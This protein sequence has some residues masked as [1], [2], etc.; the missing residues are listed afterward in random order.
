MTKI[1]KL[2]WMLVFAV[3]F[4]QM[5]QAQ[6]Q[7]TVTG[8]HA[9]SNG[10]YSTVKLAF[11]AINLQDQTGFNILVGISDNTTET[12][13]AA[14]NQGAWATLTVYPTASGK[15]ISG[16]IAGALIKLNGADNVTIDGSYNGTTQ[17]LTFS[18]DNASTSNNTIA[19]NA[20]A[21]NNTI[22]NCR[23]YSKYRS[24]TTN[25]ADNTLIEGNEIFGDSSGNPFSNQSGIYLYLNTTNAKVRR[26]NIHDIYTTN[27]LNANSWGICYRSGSTTETEISNNVIY[28]IN[29][30]GN[31][32][33]LAYQL[34]GICIYLGGNIKIFNNTIYL[35][36]NLLGKSGST[37]RSYSS[38]IY[39]VSDATNL[40]IR[41]NIL[42]N[43]MGRNPTNTSTSINTF[44]IYSDA[45]KTAFT[46][47][48]ANDYYFTNQPDVTEY[49]GFL[50]VGIT[51][52]NGWKTATGQDAGSYSTDPHFTSATNLK[53]I[54]GN[55]L[56]GENIAAITNDYEGI[57]RN[58]PPHIGAYEGTFA[59]TWTGNTDTDWNTAGN[60]NPATIPTAY[61]IITIP[62][63]PL[64]QPVINQAPASPAVCTNLTIASGA[65]LLIAPGKALTVYGSLTKSANPADLVIESGGSLI[66]NS[67]DV[68]GMVKRYLPGASQS[69]HFL[70]SPVAEQAISPDFVQ[71]PSTDYDF[72]TWYEAGDTWVNFKNTGTE[73]TWATANGISNFI[74]GRGYL[75][76][77]TGTDLI[78]AFSGNLNSGPIA[79]SLT[80]AGTGAYARYNLA[81]NPYPSAIDWKAAS[82]WDR[83]NLELNGGGYDMS[84]LNDALSTGNYGTYNSAS[85]SVT[86][87]NGVSQ[88]IPVGQGF[89]VK[90]KASGKAPLLLGIQMD[91]RVRVHNTQAYLKSTDEVANVLRMKV[92]GNVNSYSDEIVVEFGHPTADGGA[93]KMFSFS[94]THHNALKWMSPPLKH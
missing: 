49:V 70:A 7:V 89:M 41:N 44:Q 37:A 2:F 45:P 14:L 42:Y 52:L 58:N 48:N 81:G 51:N 90:A 77:Y 33:S 34:S 38:C 43:A 28:A 67:N 46:N 84:I 15:T 59:L 56:V 85:L 94:I 25:I 65:E 54:A 9:G 27:G 61:A 75:V 30:W 50:T 20:T 5:A 53:P 82:G 83:T 11:D 36:G 66:H 74:P 72:F 63:E 8:A 92:S 73:P 88:Y 24:I 80:R 4:G 10:S 6:T 17:S 12:A 79:F 26:N 13:T 86:G 55:F 57:T 60:W 39:V 69:W 32:K 93:E 64:R 68:Q 19:L 62:A 1:Y 29:G 18:N 78:K 3:A 87:T 35:S 21:D 31:D 76:E 22:K 91:D 40:D 16:T 71:D 47:I 23:L